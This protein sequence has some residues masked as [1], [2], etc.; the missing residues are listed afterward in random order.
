VVDLVA[1]EREMAGDF[2]ANGRKDKIRR[3]LLRR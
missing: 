1:E 3:K 2:A